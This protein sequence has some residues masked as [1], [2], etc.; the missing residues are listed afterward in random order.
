MP[1]LNP[2][3]EEDYESVIPAMKKKMQMTATIATKV[4]QGVYILSAGGTS[5]S[6]NLCQADFSSFTSWCK[7]PADAFHSQ[8]VGKDQ[9]C[10]RLLGI[11]HQ[12]RGS[13]PLYSINSAPL[14]MCRGQVFQETS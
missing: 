5:F 14:V 11:E 2:S 9:I 12:I 4:H 6:A 3:D 10:A 13:L 8:T 1:Q 7:E